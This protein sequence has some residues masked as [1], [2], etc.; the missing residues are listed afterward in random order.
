MKLITQRK[1][2]WPNPDAVCLEGGCGYCNYE[3]FHTIDEIRKHV[4]KHPKLE[5]A[6][7]YGSSHNWNNAETK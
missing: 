3:K 2:C 1:I 4:D 7:N 6:F 5:K